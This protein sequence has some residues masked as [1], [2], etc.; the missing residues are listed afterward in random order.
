MTFGAISS[1]HWAGEG[2]NAN[3]DAKAIFLSEARAANLL[4]VELTP[5]RPAVLDSASGP[6]PNPFVAS[7]PVI[8]EQ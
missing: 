7:S 2:L 3:A 1:D 4:W 6:G 8:S 5:P